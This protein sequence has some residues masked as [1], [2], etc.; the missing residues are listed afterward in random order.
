MVGTYAYPSRGRVSSTDR[1]GTSNTF[2]DEN[3]EI[4]R[5]GKKGGGVGYLSYV[6][7]GGREGTRKDG[8]TW[9]EKEGKD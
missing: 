5:G 6:F 1:Q 7:E 8:P 2:R 9:S 3:K 4:K